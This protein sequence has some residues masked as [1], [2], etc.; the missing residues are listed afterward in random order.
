MI[1]DAVITECEMEN[2]CNVD[3]PS[4]CVY[5]YPINPIIGCNDTVYWDIIIMSSH[6]VRPKTI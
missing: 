2:V 5:V 6:R 1:S 4:V 3:D